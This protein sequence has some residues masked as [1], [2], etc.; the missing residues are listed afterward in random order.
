MVGAWPVMR[1]Q[2]WLWFQDNPLLCLD[3]LLRGAKLPVPTAD[4]SGQI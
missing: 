4:S 3:E 1:S 2:S